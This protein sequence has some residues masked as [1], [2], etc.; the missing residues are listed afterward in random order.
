[1]TSVLYTIPIYIMPIRLLLYLPAGDIRFVAHGDWGDGASSGQTRQTYVA[2]IMDQWC[3]QSKCD[4][5]MALGD[6]FYPD[7]AEAVDDDRFNYNWRDVYTG[8]AIKD[9]VHRAFLIS[10]I[11]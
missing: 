11:A 5:I 9:L 2:D 10:L 4:F 3:S 1:M 6:N 7:G 8:D